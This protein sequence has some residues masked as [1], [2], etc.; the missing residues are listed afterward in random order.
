M[1]EITITQYLRPDGTP[2]EMKAEVPDEYA[3]RAEG[4]TLSSEVLTTGEVALYARWAN[5]PEEDE[6]S[7]LATNGPGDRDPTKMLLKH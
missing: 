4:M 3:A 1:K 5:Q 6:L 2:R 7:E